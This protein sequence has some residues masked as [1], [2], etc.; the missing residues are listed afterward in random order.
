MN[1]LL[2][3]ELIFLTAN[4]FISSGQTNVN[5]STDI[6]C[7]NFEDCYNQG[8][9]LLS[10]G[11]CTKAY[12]VLQNGIIY[13]NNSDI[14]VGKGRAAACMGDL[15]EAIKCSE[16]ALSQDNENVQAYAVKAQAL[17]SLNRSHDAH[18]VIGDA[19]AQN[20]SNPMLWIELGKIFLNE[21]MWEDAQEC[22]HKASEK[23]IHN[24]EALYF[25]A[26]ALQMM[27]RF[28][29]AILVYNQSAE[30]NSSNVNAWLGR[31]QTLEALKLFSMAEKSYSKVL[32]LDPTN[33]DALFQKGK[34]LI[35]L[36]RNDEATETFAY[37]N[38]LTPNNATAWMME[39]FAL[40]KLGECNESLAAYDKA[41]DLDENYTDAWIG[42]GDAL[43]C[44]GLITQ[45]QEVYNAALAKNGNNGPAYERKA[46]ILYLEGNYEAAI[47]YAKK[48]ISKDR[49]P[50]ANYARAWLTYANAL[51]ATHQHD[52]AIVQ[53]MVAEKKASDASPLEPGI[54]LR[55]LEWSKAS[56][57][58][59][60]ADHEYHDS[61]LNRSDYLHA[62]DFFQNLTDKNI[63]DT[64]AWMMLGIC[65]FKLWQFDKAEECFNKVLDYDQTNLTAARWCGKVTI[66]RRPR[67]RLVSFSNGDIEIPSWSDVLSDWRNWKKW[68]N[69]RPPESIS[70]ELENLADVDAIAEISIWTVPSSHVKMMR[71]KTFEISI[72]K[73]SNNITFNETVFIPKDAFINPPD[74]PL[75]LSDIQ[76]IFKFFMDIRQ[77]E[78]TCKVEAR[79]SS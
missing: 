2:L 45:A 1:R 44:L 60:R 43:L 21:H 53:Y 77:V 6:I 69:W 38:E 5:N 13:N 22:F 62:R 50:P 52:Y 66:E 14:W 78:L 24:A 39:G 31:G 19:A 72:P 48:S 11:N 29:E 74:L 30:L 37:L 20:I 46:R 28:E 7:S 79:S 55:E 16:I 70:V 42:K 23:D 65:S 41:I 71:L 15:P 36:N 49:I 54:D 18:S 58:L 64:S 10:Q 67:V 26:S 34:M 76:D 63:S 9:E 47:T 17:I 61:E 73:N 25:E 75:S 40:A 4:I 57:Y 3:A 27:G 12:E 59:H 35:L 68:V 56:A 33:E 8:M 51:N 32:D